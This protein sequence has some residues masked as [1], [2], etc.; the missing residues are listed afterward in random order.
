VQRRE[1]ARRAPPAGDGRSR[2]DRDDAVRVFAIW[3]RRPRHNASRVPARFGRSIVGPPRP[4][5]RRSRHEPRSRSAVSI[6]GKNPRPTPR[7]RVEPRS[8]RSWAK[9]NGGPGR[10]Q[11]GD[12]SEAAPRVMTHRSAD[13]PRILEGHSAIKIDPTST[14]RSRKAWKIRHRGTLRSRSGHTV[15][16]AKRCEKGFPTSP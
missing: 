14:R 16:I 2:T 9:L 12:C 15:G 6:I 8:V 7:R 5:T 3:R 4:S 1:V 11:K 13:V 10:R